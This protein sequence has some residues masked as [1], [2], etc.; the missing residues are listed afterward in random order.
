MP[1]FK[2]APKD[3]LSSKTFTELSFEIFIYVLDEAQVEISGSLPEPE[4]CFEEVTGNGSSLLVVCVA[5]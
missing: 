1:H 4:E 2:F 5:V 3:S